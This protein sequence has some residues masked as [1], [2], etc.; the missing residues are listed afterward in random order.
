MPD[1]L[2]VPGYKDA[3]ALLALIGENVAQLVAK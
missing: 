2:V 1:G 3:D